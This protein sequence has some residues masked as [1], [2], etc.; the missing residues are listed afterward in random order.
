MIVDAHHHLWR[1]ARGD[2]SWMDPR[3]N[4][5][6][7]P[8]VRDFSV[9]DYSAVA[10]AHGVGGS[11]LVQ[12]AQTVAET[13]WLLE[14]AQASAGLILGVVGWLDMAAADA[15][16]MLEQLS[17]NPLLRGIRP[18]LQN[19]PDL[20]W[21][22][23]PALDPAFRALIAHD[24]AFDLLIK[25]PHLAGAL[26]LL[27]RYPELRSVVDH[28]AKPPIAQSAWQ[29]WADQMR[30]IAR[31]TAACC[32]ISGLVTEASPHWTVEELRPYSDHLI[33]CFGPGRLM[34]GSDWPV[35][36]LAGDYAAWLEAADHLL[37]GLSAGERAGVMG[38]NAVAF[39]RLAAPRLA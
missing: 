12:A 3:A 30:R 14:Q 6:V 21:V 28:G 39:Y 5:A 20:D 1:I 37:A 15:L 35:A 38:E 8:I 36:L 33:E 9:A 19:L 23:Q 34:W 11:V 16:R 10:A 24:L 22:L 31:E 18:M 32:K 7:A 13:E 29:P 17:A 27:H 25:P 26:T 4:P 2:Y